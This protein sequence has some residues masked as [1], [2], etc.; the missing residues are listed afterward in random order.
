MSPMRSAMEHVNNQFEG[1]T[2]KTLRDVLTSWGFDAEDFEIDAND[3]LGPASLLAVDG[4]IIA[5]RCV[6]TGVERLYA[7]GPD[8]A[9]FGA[10]FMDLGWGCFAKPRKPERWVRGCPLAERTAASPFPFRTA[11][12]F[13][14]GVAAG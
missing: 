9:W 8:S 4:G 5:V 12:H 3:G 13:D 7:T 11:H 10:F 14:A 2:G 6:K 1:Q